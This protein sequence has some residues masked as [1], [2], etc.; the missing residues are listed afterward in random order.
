MQW[1]VKKRC[2][3][4][5]I[6]QYN[7]YLHE[8]VCMALYISTTILPFSYSVYSGNHNQFITIWPNTL[9]LILHIVHI[10]HCIQW[11]G[12][13]IHISLVTQLGGIN[14]LDI[15]SSSWSSWPLGILTTSLATQWK[16]IDCTSGRQTLLP[17][18]QITV[19]CITSQQ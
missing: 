15:S 9:W 3:L 7:R 13:Y 2:P 17:L 12:M 18:G 4:T 1:F 11:C 5:F 16:Q 19:L 8:Y 6:L 14:R 10:E